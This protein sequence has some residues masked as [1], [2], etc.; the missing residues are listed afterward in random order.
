MAPLEDPQTAAGPLISASAAHGAESVEEGGADAL[1]PRGSTSAGS[2]PVWASDAE[3]AS[4]PER[5]PGDSA[6]R[7]GGTLGRGSYGRASSSAGAGGEAVP[8]SGRGFSSF[9]SAA[10]RALVEGRPS[11]RGVSGVTNAW[12]SSRHAVAVTAQKRPH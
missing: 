5:R 4:T 12:M 6:P 7:V 11:H 10:A 8:G 9:S 3:G 1:A 2:P